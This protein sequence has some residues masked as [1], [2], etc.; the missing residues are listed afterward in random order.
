M[1]SGMLSWILNTR[2]HASK[3]TCT[4]WPS[5]EIRLTSMTLPLHSWSLEKISSWNREL[6]PSDNPS[7][8]EGVTCSN[9]SEGRRCKII[10]RSIARSG[11]EEAHA[12]SRSKNYSISQRPPNHLSLQHRTVCV[13]YQAWSGCRPPYSNCTAQLL[14]EGKNPALQGLTHHQVRPQR[15]L[16]LRN[17]Y[18][19]YSCKERELIFAFYTKRAY[20]R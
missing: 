7:P 5:A 16:Q 20:I 17:T 1:N 18:Q 12:R 2:T 9:T 15:T 6:R 10:S 11:Y 4:H 3:R 19:S 13:R 14:S 8:S